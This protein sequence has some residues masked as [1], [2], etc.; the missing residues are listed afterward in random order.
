M[1][2]DRAPGPEVRGSTDPAVPSSDPMTET[3]PPPGRAIASDHRA[4]RPRI[5]ALDGLRGLAV[6][7]VVAYHLEPDL[8]PG[9]F[10]GVTMFFVL[11]GYLI[12]G[13]LLA[14]STADQ[15]I[16][17]G[18]FWKRRIRRLLPAGLLGIAVAIVV[19]QWVGD[20]H[21]LTT[22]PGDVVGGVTYTLNWHFI[23]SGVQYGTA[24]LQP[25]VLQHYWSLAIEEQF[26][27]LIS[28]LAALL[29][30][31]VRRRA[32]WGAVLGL[33][34]AASLGL[35]FSIGV[36]HR[37][38]IYFNTG[39]R[40]VEMLV[41]SLLAVALT[42]REARLAASAHRWW[43]LALGWPAIAVLAWLV[44]TVDVGETWLYRGGFTVVALVTALTIVAAHLRSPF[45][46][47]MAR[48]ALVGIGLVSYGIYVYHWPLF[49]LISPET[50][51]LTGVG[52]IAA[53]LSATAVL[54]LLSYWLV[55]TPIRSGAFEGH[56]IAAIAASCS[57]IALVCV[58]SVAV[59]SGS[60][61]RARA[62][63][64][65]TDGNPAFEIP[66]N[67]GR[68]TSIVVIGDSIL[69]DSV[70]ALRDRAR[71]LDID[72]IALGG[73]RQTL[74]QYRDAWFAA[75]ADAVDRLDPDVVVL[76]S[77]TGS[78]DPYTTRDGTVIQPD[79]PRFWVEWENESRRLT[80]LAGSRGA[81]V[82][83]VLPPPVDGV[84]SKWYGDV[85]ERMR[86]VSMIERRIAGDDPRVGLIDWTV[87]GGPD[88][89][90]TPVFVD[91]DGGIT[92]IRARDGTHFTPAGR[93]LLAQTTLAQII[94]QWN[95]R[96]GR[97]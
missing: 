92:E 55:E 37:F 89:G 48:R 87:L 62:L 90:Y 9:G 20:A 34:A 8:V 7:A 10:L 64:P 96:G 33:L 5:R 26:Y 13:L 97:P 52:L 40:A 91:S 28:L 35:T 70:P 2:K 24:Y 77:A 61:D 71:D 93:E 69:H 67:A 83:W 1:S 32:V 73:P 78:P 16:D 12:T 60:T 47:V 27:I 88:G 51:P 39:T 56:R 18:S 79:D 63:A 53:R 59:S 68:P 36:E 14:E 45:S 95:E 22:L 49:I 42:G 57:A 6:I 81:F 19:A 4:H 23:A 41:G 43:F 50:T 84:Y 75:V 82:L 54:T 74:F 80:E 85:D 72:F 66:V 17:L 15:H 25:S 58:A 94:R 65:P 21:Q 46:W 30:W 38:D 11:S 44:L 29:A 31:K 3:I 76:E 86:R